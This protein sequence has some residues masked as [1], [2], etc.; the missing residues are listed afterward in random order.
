MA[1]LNRELS[2]LNSLLCPS[3]EKVS[4]YRKLVVV[5]SKV[6]LCFNWSSFWFQ[7]ATTKLSLAGSSNV[8]E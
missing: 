1:V 7:R 4:I 8:K 6:N 5:Y 3:I 2:K